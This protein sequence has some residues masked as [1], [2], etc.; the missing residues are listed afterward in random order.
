M[1][2]CWAP[3]PSLRAPH[4]L[5]QAAGALVPLQLALL[6]GQPAIAEGASISRHT[7]LSAV[8][9]MVAV[10]AA[11]IPLA[12]MSLTKPNLTISVD[13]KNKKTV[14]YRPSCPF[15]NVSNFIPLSYCPIVIE[16]TLVSDATEPLV[17]LSGD[18]TVANISF[19]WNI[20]Q[21]IITWDIH[22]L[23][24]GLFAEYAE[25]LEKQS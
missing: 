3:P 8:G 6:A 21:P 12:L 5:R 13:L 10:A 15:F 7:V 4:R 24:D 16:L 22:Q 11:S 9:V 14:C 19:L 20:E 1:P 23:D 17:N 18:F 2:V 25:I